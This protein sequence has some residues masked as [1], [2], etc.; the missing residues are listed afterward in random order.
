MCN[1]PQNFYDNGDCCLASIID[2]FCHN[3]D[4]EDIKGDC[5]CHEDNTRHPGLEGKV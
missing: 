3:L 4:M 1:V 2:H 5:Q